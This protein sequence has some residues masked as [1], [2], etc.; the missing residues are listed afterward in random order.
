MFRKGSECSSNSVINDRKMAHIR[1]SCA[2]EMI[3][4]LLILPEYKVY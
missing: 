3:F 1:Y 4:L 2:P